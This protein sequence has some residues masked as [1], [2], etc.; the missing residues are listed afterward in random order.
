MSLDH[1]YDFV[2]ITLYVINCGLPWIRD[3]SQRIV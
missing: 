1:L 3:G 2:Y